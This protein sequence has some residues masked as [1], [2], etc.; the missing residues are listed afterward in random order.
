MIRTFSPPS[1]PSPR[2]RDAVGD[3]GPGLTGLVGGGSAIQY[4]LDQAINSDLRL[5]V[6]IALAVIAVILALLLWSLVAP[7]VLIASVILSFLCTLGISMLFIRY[8]VGDP[9]V[10]ASLPTFAFI[11]LVA[12]GIDYTIFLM[13]GCARSAPPRHPR[14]DAARACGHG[15]RDHERRDHPRR[16]VLGPDDVAGHL[17]VRSRVD[18]RAG[19]LLD[20]FIVRTIMVPAAVELI[21]DKIWWPSTAERGGALRERRRPSRARRPR[22]APPPP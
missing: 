8:V 6:P 22:A 18:G 7:L 21:G 10:D 12:L 19:I 3:L 13:A 14:R 11:F 9:G 4:D 16:H 5:I 17:H 2:V 1:T 15:S 20:T